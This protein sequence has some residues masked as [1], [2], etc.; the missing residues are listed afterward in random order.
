MTPLRAIL[1]T[2]LLAVSTAMAAEVTIGIIAPLSGNNS[3]TGELA[4]QAAL[5][6][7][8]TLDQRDLTHSYKLI[9]EDDQMSPRLTV[10][11]AQKLINIDKVDGIVCHGIAPGNVIAPMA[12]RA[13]IPLIC[14]N[15]SF[16]SIADGQTN[17]LHWPPVDSESEA[18]AQLLKAMGKTKATTIVWRQP[19]VVKIV[20]NIEKHLNANGIEFVQRIS[21]NPGERDFRT[22][23]LRL[24][25]ADADVF[26][27]FAVSPELDII[28][29]QAQELGYT[30][31]MA[32]FEI[33]NFLG[34]KNLAN[35]HYFVSPSIGTK[36]FQQRLMQ[37]SGGPSD[38]T[39]AYV[40]DSLALLRSAYETQDAEAPD[41]AA[42]AK[43]IA[44][45]NNYN[46][47]VGTISM[48]LDG[49]IDSPI[50]TFQMQNGTPVEITLEEIN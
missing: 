17:F 10:S 33:F 11:A 4:R 46:S 18:L 14:V 44:S 40:Y 5:Y 39:V 32:A 9:F 27:P 2:L 29:R 50:K 13:G 15:A 49:I 48:G 22:P 37:A 30:P 42:A 41:H 7:Q 31:D 38:Y 19:G 28:L 23:L 35:G 43:W 20:D 21:F 16:A 3:Y 47:A 25:E 12:K 26:V 6:W 1:A 45:L 24:A 36:E 8:N 34:D